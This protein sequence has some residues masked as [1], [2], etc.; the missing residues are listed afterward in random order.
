VIQFNFSG[1]SRRSYWLLIEQGNVSVCLKHPGFEI[2]VTVSADIVAFYR[3]WLGRA[4]LSEAVRRRQVRLEGVPAN[5]RAF[6]RWFSWS[7][8]SETVRAAFAE[9]PIRPS[10]D[11][12]SKLERKKA[13]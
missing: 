2:S 6:A 1:G 3:V 9:R 4:A 13:G 10:T 8:M 7:P 5:V 11:L 12:S